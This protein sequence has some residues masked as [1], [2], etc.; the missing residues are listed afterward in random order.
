MGQ[1]LPDW[2]PWEDYRQVYFSKKETGACREML[3]FE[4]I[5]LNWLMGSE[6]AEVSGYISKISDLDMNADDIIL[7]NLKYKN[8]IIGNVIIDVISRKPFRTLRVLG[9]E[10]ALDWERFDSVIKIYNAKAKTTRIV[11]VPK[12]RPE[13][14]YINEEEMYHDEV[15]VFLRAVNSE[16][17]YPHTF[18]DSLGLLKTLSALEKSNRTGRIIFL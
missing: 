12:G 17:K 3:P 15:G 6:V 7:A 13:K 16:G 1:Y 10:G 11:S 14:G 18:A 2:H 9:S 8:G 4:L 5:W